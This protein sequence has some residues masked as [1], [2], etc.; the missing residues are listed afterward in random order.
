[1]TKTFLKYRRRIN[2]LSFLILLS[3][4]GLC[5]RFAYIQVIHGGEYRAQGIKQGKIREPLAAVRGNIYD[6]NDNPL[7]KNIIHY[8]IAAFPKMVAD[9]NQIA[10]VLNEQTGISKDQYLKKLSSNK[11]FVYLARNLSKELGEPVASAKLKGLSIERRA[12][13]YYPHAQ[14][15]SQILGFADVDDNG[16]SGIEQRLDRFISGKPGWIVKQKDGLGGKSV[17]VSF[18]TQPAVDGS[19]VKL[20]VDL[21]YQTILQEELARRYEETNATS[22]TG[23]IIN[24]QNG[25]V[26]SIASY[27]DFDPNNPS[28]YPIESQKNKAFTDQFE[29][30]S[31]FKIV[32]ATAALDLNTVKSSD[33]FNCENGSYIYKNVT[34]NDHEE[35]DNLTF[36]QIIE[37]SS[38]VGIIKVA[39]TLDNE[40]L[41]NYAVKYGFGARTNINMPGETPGMLRNSKDWSD[42]SLAEIA[43]G[44]EVGVTA[45]QLAM[46]Y[47]SIANGGFLL[48]PYIIQNV[49]TQAGKTV[50]TEK[51]EV[52]RKVVN[53]NVSAQLKDMLVK[54]VQSGTGTEAHI[55]GWNIAGKTGTAQKFIDGKY[56]QTK[57]ISNFVGFFPAENPQLLAVIILN[58]P[59]YPFHW[60]GIGAAPVFKRVMERIIMLDDSIIFP[61]IKEP[62]I[63]QKPMLVGNL[64]PNSIEQNSSKNV[65]MSTVAPAISKRISKNSVVIM[66]EVRGM[67][68]RKAISTLQDSGLRVKFSGSGRVVWQSPKPNA[69]IKLKTQCVIGLE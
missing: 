60:G 38:N 24:P 46:A 52:I 14:I 26:L 39:E 45:F 8:S 68:L 11:N 57:F 69:S 9:K 36:A 3:W 66:P 55:P 51:P 61:K 47:A 37:H 34:I 1:M 67:S 21:E 32:A 15:C 63:V 12:R 48:K 54:V 19:N 28:Q 58:E 64:K 41:H 22:A 7:T 20:T 43:M 62:E 5:T 65:Y 16:I 40:I 35:Y 33:E 44:H 50:Y 56:S 10:E 2:L 25:A 29:P 30:G 59:R 53:Q 6:R 4:L 23:I 42:I 18:P 27:P 31:T 13:R 49:N 17:D